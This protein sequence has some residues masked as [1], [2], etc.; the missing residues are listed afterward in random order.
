[1]MKMIEDRIENTFSNFIRCCEERFKDFYMF[2]KKDGIE[3]VYIYG[4][5]V[6]GKFLKNAFLDY[7]ITDNVTAFIN[8]YDYGV[9][10]ENTN[11]VSLD[12]IDISDENYCII[13]GLQKADKV[14]EKLNGK[15]LEFI[16]VD[17]K[18]K[19]IQDMMMYYIYHC[20]EMVAAYNPYDKFA[21]YHKYLA[22]EKEKIK[23]FYMDEKSIS[24][25]TRRIQFF[26]T[27]D[28]VF[29]EGENYSP[30]QYFDEEYLPLGNDEI[31][32]D[33]GAFNGDTILSFCKHVDNKYNKIIA[34]EPDGQNYRVLKKQT[35][36]FDRI[37]L[38]P[39]ATGG[40]NCDLRFVETGGLGAY[41]SKDGRDVVKCVT[42]DS[43]IK[44][45]VTLIKMDIEGA[46]LDTLKGAREIITTYH[47]K[48]M[49]SIYHNGEDILAIPEYIRELCQDYKFKVRQHEE[50]MLELVLYA[51]V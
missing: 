46:E 20:I 39:Y 35:A 23:G 38:Y 25:M 34:F 19:Y 9:T 5:G 41:I 30:I 51:W 24:L 37:I 47:P 44:D 26:E 27:G 18:Q 6:Y 33:C 22:A 49:I 14:I 42:L 29:L 17:Q 21:Y 15:G 43:V 3:R 40:S 2:V 12:E 8:D 36:R 13:L 10:V 48:L 4:S 11:V 50:T 32:I 28:Y 31:Y 45:P 7:G 1:M 16:V